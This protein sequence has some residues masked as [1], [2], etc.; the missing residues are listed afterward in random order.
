M[1]NNYSPSIISPQDYVFI[2]GLQLKCVIGIDDEERLTP[3]NVILDV[4]IGLDVTT[5][6][7][8]DDVSDTID[9]SALTDRLVDF[10]ESSSFMLL[11][12]LAVAIADICFD[13]KRATWVQVSVDKP[14]A[15]TKA[16]KVGVTITRHKTG[17][18]EN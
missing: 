16:S 12:R 15:A 11:E 6:S 8:S 7:V 4:S 10:V 13:E 9:Y 1:N 14:S 17:F 18:Q 3:Q 5:A 2:N